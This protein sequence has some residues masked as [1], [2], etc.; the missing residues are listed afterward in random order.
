MKLIIKII[1]ILFLF[2]ST[3][4]AYEDD[5]I[6]KIY[7]FIG[8]QGASTQ[9]GNTDT[10]TIGFKYGKQTSE[11]R[12]ALIY[13]YSASSDDIFHSFIIQVDKGILTEMFKDMP[14]K[15]YL[16]FSIGVMQHRND[17]LKDRGYL[18]GGNVGFNYVLNREF[19]IDLGYRYMTA[20][21]F[22]DLDDRGDIALS[23]HY[24]FE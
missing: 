5:G 10:P 11:W 8:I 1:A 15:P 12:T 24:Y 16:G 3:V 9:Y 14:F 4:S 23:L 20:S 22:E 2:N 18:F 13:N 7:T 21:K 17:N 19:D 6:D